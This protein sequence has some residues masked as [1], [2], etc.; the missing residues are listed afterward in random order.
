[1][2]FNFEDLDEPVLPPEILS[3]VTQRMI[4]HFS[5]DLEDEIE[6]IITTEPIIQDPVARIVPPPAALPTDQQRN[7]DPSQAAQIGLIFQFFDGD[8]GQPPQVS[9]SL[10]YNDE[11][12]D[13]EVL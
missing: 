12:I 1:M 9:S 8:M 11:E 7:H 4:Q 6:G 5:E 13:D 3:S 2:S 10:T